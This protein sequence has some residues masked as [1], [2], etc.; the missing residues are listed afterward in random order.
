MNNLQPRFSALRILLVGVICLVISSFPSASASAGE[1]ETQ[2]SWFIDAAQY[3]ASAHGKLHCN[4]CHEA[5]EKL[6]THPSPENVTKL[7][8]SF[9]TLK[10]CAGSDCH[11]NT[12]KD[13]EKNQHG[14]IQF[15]NREKYDFCID[16]HNPH[17]T[18]ISL[19]D[20]SRLSKIEGRDQCIYEDGELINPSEACSKDEDCLVCHKQVTDNIELAVVR[21]SDLCFK[22][23]DR[24]GDIHRSTRKPVIPPMDPAEYRKSDHSEIRC[25]QCH[26]KSASFEHQKQVVGCRDC[27]L[28]HDEEMTHDTHASIN[29]EACHLP[30]KVVKAVIPGGGVEW[31]KDKRMKKALVT[32]HDLVSTE[33]DD[34]CLRCHISENSIGAAS[35]ILPPKSVICISCH[36][37]TFTVGDRVSAITLIAFLLVI[38]GLFS[39]WMSGGRRWNKADG[40]ILKLRDLTLIILKVLFSI[41]V[42]QIIKAVFFDAIIQRKLFHQSKIRW[43]AHS[44]ILH[45]FLIRI[46]WGLCALVIS[47]I[48]PEWQPVWSMLN[49]NYPLV[50]FLFDFTGVM[51][52]SGVIIILLRKLF[53][54]S[55]KWPGLPKQEWL[56]L[57]LIG[58]IIILGFVLEGMRIS[59]TTEI[60][61]KQF[62]YLGFAISQL[63]DNM[64]G[65]TDIYGYFWYLH[66]ILTGAFII[67]LPFSR[68][69]HIVM[70]PV[71][72]AINAVWQ[73]E[74]ANPH[75]STEENM[76]EL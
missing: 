18:Q 34:N 26:T 62:A 60:P 63:F 57:S 20:D 55:R 44:L 71:T 39:V 16:C 42:F 23:H 54:K 29:C 1:Y 61:G 19:K 70:A 3:T 74:G 66:A 9:F 27:H 22:C 69:F 15:K 2:F 41:R 11:E 53:T 65:L 38:F 52:I 21:E 28:P 43:L 5:V 10:Q 7:P 59:M 50:A 37:A 73:H 75:F 64:K 58:S 32:V 14:R 24:K 48:W 67:W 6:E 12:L 36:T 68:M 25:T 56:S 13:L 51:I 76:E 17:L 40:F 72:I 33:K 35:M 49:K 47:L 4:Q 8:E 30:G 46:V 31:E 45:G